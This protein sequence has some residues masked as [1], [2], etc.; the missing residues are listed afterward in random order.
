MSFAAGL[1][2]VGIVGGIILLVTLKDVMSEA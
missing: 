1:T 2:I